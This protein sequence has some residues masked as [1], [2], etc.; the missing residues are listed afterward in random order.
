MP[1]AALTIR[2]AAPADLPAILEVFTA[3]FMAEYVSH[4][5]IWEGRADAAGAP[6]PSAPALLAA[7]LPRM[8]RDFP[9][10]VQVAESAGRLIGFA[11]AKIDNLGA[12]DFGVINDLCVSPEARR[13]G[14]GAA[15]L[16]AVFDALRSRSVGAVFLE[17]NLRNTTAHRLF[18]EAGFQPISQVFM[19]RL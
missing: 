9:G 5:E 12:A 15:L 3:C 19:K 7:E 13:R 14:V 18:H 17:T 10:G 11:A 4:S 6:S 1:D 16:N 8:I 2:P